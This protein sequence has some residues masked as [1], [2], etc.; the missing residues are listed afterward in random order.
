MEEYSPKHSQQP[1]APVDAN[2]KSKNKRLIWY[3][4]FA[5]SAALLLT[6][7]VVF[8]V[9][10]FG[11][12]E[13]FDH[14]KTT[15]TVSTSLPAN[16]IDFAA[17]QADNPD[18]CAW[19]QVD[20]TVIDYP[21][22]QSATEEDDNFY[23]KH[24]VTGAQKAAG[25]IY[26]QKLNDSSFTDPNTVIYGH[27]MLNGTMFGQLKKFK[28]KDFFNENRYI[29]VYTPGHILKYEI[30]SSFVYD[31]RHIL[32]SFNFNIANEC[33]E[34]FNTCVNPT[35]FTKNI[36]D[37]AELTTSDKIITLSTCTGNDSERY[38]VIGKQ[39]EDTLTAK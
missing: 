29:Y 15:S 28:N 34:F 8:C 22:L 20:G 3:I 23:L 26:I 37:G 4:A 18:I 32:N 9:K 38:L 5:I 33:E 39:I 11:G 30:I 36:V 16:P 6:F 27:N 21:V 35:S 12:R 24:D 14:Y 10:F 17:A 1:E 25:A 7:I 2:K 31:N 13:N 19:I